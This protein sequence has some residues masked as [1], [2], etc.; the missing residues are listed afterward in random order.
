MIE[1]LTLETFLITLFWQGFLGSALACAGFGVLFNVRGKSLYAAAFIGGIGGLVY[2]LCL[3]EQWSNAMA[4]FMAATVLSILAEFFAR[5][6]K[7]TVTAFTACALIPLVPGGTAYEMM[8]EFS[9]GHAISGWVKL[10]DVLTVSGMLAMGILLVSTL[11]RF[12]YYSKGQLHKTKQKIQ[13]IP[14]YAS[15]TFLHPNVKAFQ[16]RHS[17]FKNSRDFSK[18]SSPTSSLKK[19]KEKSSSK[20]PTK[21]N[22][23]KEKSA[24]VNSNPQKF[25]EN[26]LLD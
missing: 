7:N 23:S 8:L 15:E 9:E 2:E 19:Y 25:D 1:P 11:T 20:E 22:S 17:S 26:K 14:L 4:N 16:K 10:L 13:D 6:L 24:Y 5:K 18:S 12:F 21:K 3:I